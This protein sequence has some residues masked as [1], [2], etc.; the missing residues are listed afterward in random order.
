MPNG[1]TRRITGALTAAKVA[2]VKEPGKYHDGGGTGLFLRVDPNGARFWVQRIT[3]R[4]ARREI[5]LGTPE[6][7]S[8]AKARDTAR[9]NRRLAYEGLDPLQI[10]REARAV[11]TFAEA[12]RKV[13]EIHLPTWRNE[14]HGAQFISTLETY[15]FPKLGNIRISD[16]TPADV[17]GALTPI[18]TKKPETARRV[19]QRIVTV[20]KWAVAKGWRKDNPAESID[21]ALP[22]V[23]KAKEHRQ[24]L[25]YGDVAAA[26]ATVQSSGAGLSTKLCL[27]FLVLCAARSGE[28]RGAEWSEIDLAAKVWTIPPSRMKSGRPHRVPLSKRAIEL[29]TEAKALTGGTGLIFPG[30][31]AGKPLSDMTL[32]KL[33]KRDLE[34]A[35]DIHGFRTSFRTW[36]QERSAFPREVA[37]A[38]LAHVVGDTT[39]QAYARSDV[40]EKRRKM[41]ESWSL[42]LSAESGK[43]IGLRRA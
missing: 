18:W 23:T 37:E 14:K 15:A 19:R 6:L 5:G 2:T 32:S 4:G 40:F 29:L 26:L 27:E 33:V 25:P 41:M 3:I 8:L 31:K 28:A 30:T 43:V 42:F 16:V 39:E 38:A 7:V 13:H 11:L 22:R 12:A 1:K 24:A 36:A 21:L 10:R 20:M 35:T 34:I 17:L 9:E